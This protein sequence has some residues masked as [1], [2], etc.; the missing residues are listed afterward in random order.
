MRPYFVLPVV[1]LLAS[2]A[3]HSSSASSQASPSPSSSPLPLHS[4]EVRDLTI[5]GAEAVVQANA[6]G[7]V[8]SIVIVRAPDEA[9]RAKAYQDARSDF[10]NPDP[11]TRTQ[12]RQYKDGLPEITDYCGRPV[13]PNA[14]ASPAPTASVPT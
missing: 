10:G 14:S 7:S 4:C 1:L 5:D 9:T 11:D 6:D 3:G 13:M 2:C 12:T 8:A